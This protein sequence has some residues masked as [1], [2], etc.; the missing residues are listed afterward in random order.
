MRSPRP[1]S[2]RPPGGRAKRDVANARSLRPLRTLREI[3]FAAWG[4][5]TSTLIVRYSS[6]DLTKSWSVLLHHVLGSAVEEG[7]RRFDFLSG[8]EPY[9]YEWGAKDHPY[10]ART[11]DRAAEAIPA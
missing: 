10:F 8:Q 7:V 1:A 11:L 2:G 9:K 4:A 5:G 6:S 3:R